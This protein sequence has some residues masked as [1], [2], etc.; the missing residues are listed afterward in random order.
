MSPATGGWFPP[1]PASAPTTQPLCFTHRMWHILHR[2][3]FRLTWSLTVVPRAC[4]SIWHRRCSAITDMRVRVCVYACEVDNTC[5]IL[6][7]NWGYFH[8]QEICVSLFTCAASL[9]HLSSSYVT[10]RTRGLHFSHSPL[11]NAVQNFTDTAGWLKLMVNECTLWEHFM[12]KCQGFGWWD[13]CAGT[14]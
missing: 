11:G 9:L 5:S 13:A 12:E 4:L 2:S 8:L 6:T 7:V 1:F 14:A 3:G 10:Q